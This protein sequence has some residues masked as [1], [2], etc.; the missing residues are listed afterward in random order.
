MNLKMSMVSGILKF[1]A[2]KNTRGP[3]SDKISSANRDCSRRQIV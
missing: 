3:V 2:R 1:M